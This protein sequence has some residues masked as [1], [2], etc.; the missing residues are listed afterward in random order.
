MLVASAT[1][2]TPHGPIALTISF[3]VALGLPDEG[4][5]EIMVRVDR[6]L[7]EAKDAGRNRAVLDV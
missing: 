5:P 2:Q 3:G 7:Y 4:A 6:A 1:V